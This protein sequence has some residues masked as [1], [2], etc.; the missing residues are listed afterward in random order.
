MVGEA[1]ELPLRKH[2]G[3]FV[4]LEGGEGA[5]KST[6]IGRLRNRLEE[7]GYEVVTTRE[8]GGSPRA[9]SIRAFVL[10]GHATSFGGFGETL[11]F[12]A[13]RADHVDRAIR[14]A[15]ERGAVVLCDRFAD[16]TRV[17]QGQLA[18]IPDPVIAA[19]ERVAVGGVRPDLT[20]ILDLPAKVG[21]ARAAR[22]RELV[23]EQADRYEREEL[24]F[25]TR[26]REGFLAIAAS[27]PN[28]CVV[29]D[30]GKEPHAVEEDMWGAVSARLLPPET[31]EG[32]RRHGG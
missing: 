20:L 22:R 7:R 28:R 3:W 6:Q 21:L 2:P 12:A 29:L 30:A 27:E 4:T 8:P 23:H 11:L 15:V 19:L 31:N 1:G 24:A 10:D 14:P 17:Y 32:G 16:S 25:H 9:E 13:A 5:G 18:G 26:V